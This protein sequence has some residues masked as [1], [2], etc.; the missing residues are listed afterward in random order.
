[1]I[2]GGG[3]QPN[4]VP[5]VA[6]VWYYFREQDFD[7]IKENFEL[8]NEIAEGAAKMT[9]TTVTRRIVGTAA[10]RHFNRP[11]AEAAYANIKAV[12]LPEWTEGEQAF[13]KLVPKNVGAE[14]IDGLATALEKLEPPDEAPENGGTGEKGHGRTEEGR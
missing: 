2:T 9:G 8:G 12:G 13:A 10:P 14:E 3:D 4:V 5:A 11:I 7:R 6:S 1:M